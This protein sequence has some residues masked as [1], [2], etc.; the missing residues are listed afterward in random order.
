MGFPIPLDYSTL[1]EALNRARRKWGAKD[2]LDRLKWFLIEG[3]V[4]VY[5]SDRSG[6]SKYN[7]ATWAKSD[8][9]YLLAHSE[10]WYPGRR[11]W[12]SSSTT[13]FKTSELDEVLPT[14]EQQEER[15]KALQEI[16]ITPPAIEAKDKGGRPQKH[17]WDSIWVEMCAFIDREGPPNK[18]A[19]LVRHIQ[20]LL[21]GA[22]PAQS[23]IHAKAKL[24]IDRIRRDQG[25][26]PIT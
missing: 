18:Y 4:S 21:G 11:D 6:L 20:E 15:E 9:E 19:V 23:A 26:T 25:S 8:N 2:A 3:K 10:D 13:L 14:I 7:P 1:D 16:P 22:A 24:L 17:D 5:K 12:N